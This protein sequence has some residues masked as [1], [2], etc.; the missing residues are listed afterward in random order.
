MEPQ[1][2]PDPPTILRPRSW[3]PELADSALHGA[4]GLSSSPQRWRTPLSREAASPPPWCPPPPPCAASGGVLSRSGVPCA[5]EPVFFSS[6]GLS[7][8]HFRHKNN[9]MGM[10]ERFSLPPCPH[11]AALAAGLGPHAGEGQAGGGGSIRVTKGPSQAWPC[12]QMR[13]QQRGGAL[14]KALW[15]L[16]GLGQ[17]GCLSVCWFQPWDL[18]ITQPPALNPAFSLPEL[19]RS[20]TLLCPSPGARLMLRCFGVRGE[21]PCGGKEAPAP[22]GLLSAPSTPAPPPTKGPSSGALCIGVSWRNKVQTPHIHSGC[23]QRW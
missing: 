1:E 11:T 4:D 6:P 17:V 20:H 21:R 12:P 22:S 14:G 19:C 13:P 8:R 15:V 5:S 10:N 23:L 16:G 2:G 3:G 18:P 9:F 7:H